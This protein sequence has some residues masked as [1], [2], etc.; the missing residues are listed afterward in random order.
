LCPKNT[1]Q[2]T[3][4]DMNIKRKA[5]SKTFRRILDSVSPKR[6]HLGA[7]MK[8][9]SL[10]VNR[11][12]RKTKCGEK[13]KF[14]DDPNKWFWMFIGLF[15]SA[16]CF[17]LYKA[18]YSKNELLR[19]GAA[20]SLTM[21][22]NDFALYSI[23][24]INARSK[25][26]RG[27]NVGFGEMTRNIIKNEGFQSMYKGYSASFYSIIVHSFVY[28]YIYKALK[29]IMKDYFNPQTTTQKAM[30]YGGASAVSQ[31]IDLICYPL[32][33]IRIRLLTMN[34]VY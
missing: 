34:D 11:W 1:I 32:E 19:F 26:L 2:A 9:E 29:Q 14:R 8:F 3:D 31:S 27:E 13:I 22:V 4:K 23:E 18:K 17:V 30:I 28:F 7:H 33:M 24:S 5:A 6:D 21:V 15:S 25:I 16:F 10:F 20:G 12:S